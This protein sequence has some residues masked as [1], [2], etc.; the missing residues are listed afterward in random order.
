VIDEAH[1]VLDWWFDVLPPEKQFVRDDAVDAEIR[2]KFGAIHARLS[3]GVPDAWLGD[4]KSML[5]AIIV[6]DQFSRNLFRDDAQAFANDATSRGLTE[7]AIARRWDKEL[8]PEE[9]AFLYMPLM[10]SEY[11]PDV[12]QC[13][14]LMAASGLDDNAA[15]AARHAETIRKF[16]RYPARN[17]ALGRESTKAEVELLS[18][19]PAGF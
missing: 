3:Q 13:Q 11:L 10:H 7:T 14:A 19:N 8:T 5:A 18:K 17:E 1:A 16:G 15:F 6:L 2:A 9:R 12:E 4:A